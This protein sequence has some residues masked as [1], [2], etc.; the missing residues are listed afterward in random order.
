MKNEINLPG[1]IYESSLGEQINHFK[2]SFNYSY[3]KNNIVLP[4]SCRKLLKRC[5][6]GKNPKSRACNSWVINC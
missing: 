5:L 6:A 1:F 3:T 2:S 4:S